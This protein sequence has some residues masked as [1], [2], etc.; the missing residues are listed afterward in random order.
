MRKISFVSVFIVTFIIFV[1]NGRTEDLSSRVIRHQFKNGL[2]LLMVER[3]T[4]PT[5]SFHITYKAGSV[6]EIPGITGIAHL[7]EHM[8]F[9]GTEKIG[10]KDYRAEKPILD[11]FH[12]VACA[13]VGMVAGGAA[14]RIGVGSVRHTC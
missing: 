14:V 10:T 4:S 11:E 9:K 7:Y 5:V 13:L 1:G 2:V 6:N 8:A 3:H 12:G